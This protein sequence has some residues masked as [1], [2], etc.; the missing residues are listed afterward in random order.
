VQ[1][2]MDHS[3]RYISLNGGAA[4]FREMRRRAQELSEQTCRQILLE[5]RRGVLAVLGDDEYPYAV[6]MNFFY[7]AEENILYFHGAKEG[8]KPDA[9]RRHDKVSFC[10]MEELGGK[11]GDWARSVR[12]VIVFGRVRLIDDE[13]QAMDAARAIARKYYPSEE[14][15]EREVEKAA[16]RAL[17]FAME[18][19]HMT[20]KQVR[21]A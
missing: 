19:E 8:H 9:L 2:L 15:A 13:K 4:M 11:E 14:Q 17:C 3:G 21:E 5:G 16:S 20:G 10:V 6:P 18:P 12:S 7:D 1:A